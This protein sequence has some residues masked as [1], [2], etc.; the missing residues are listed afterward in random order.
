MPNFSP[1][2][3]CVTPLRVTF[4]MPKPGKAKGGTY[5]SPLF[6]SCPYKVA[7]SFAIRNKTDFEPHELFLWSMVS[8]KPAKTGRKKVRSLIS[9]KVDKSIDTSLPLMCLRGSKFL[10]DVAFITY[11]YP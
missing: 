10:W 4:S 3:V 8:R 11:F 1:Y 9:K 5:I 2:F 7:R 6:L